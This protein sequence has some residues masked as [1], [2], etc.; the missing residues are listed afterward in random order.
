[1]GRI[2]KYIEDRGFGF[3]EVIHPA[4]IENLFFHITSIEKTKNILKTSPINEKYLIDDNELFLFEIE[5]NA[6]GTRLKK[7]VTL[8]NINNLPDK[9][10]LID[11]IT[12][13]WTSSSYTQL[14]SWLTE[15]TILLLGNDKQKELEE[16]R[17]QSLEAEKIA[18]EKERLKAQEKYQQELEKQRI[19]DLIKLNR[20]IDYY[21]NSVSRYH[22]PAILNDLRVKLS[23]ESNLYD[24]EE[25]VSEFEFNQML[26]EF[27]NKDFS[28][29]SQVSKYIIYNNIG[30]K[31]QYISG[32]LQMMRGNNHDSVWN[33]KGGIAPQYFA[34][35]CQELGLG[36]KETNARVVSFKSFKY[37]F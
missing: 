5:N 14:P 32:N 10:T 36:T 29:S 34:R 26:K 37:D 23:D 19:E 12:S 15:A 13:Y 20:E 22:S 17:K 30:K 7:I 2:N 4:D 27:E 21:I 31:Y 33:F 35:L 25:I 18:A 1:M 16:N 28:L 8:N 11:K 6:K 9:E 24:F 3:I